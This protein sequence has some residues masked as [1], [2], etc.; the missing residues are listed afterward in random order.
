MIPVSA[1]S[2]SLWGTFFFASFRLSMYSNSTIIRS[3][4]MLSLAVL[5][6]CPYLLWRSACH[7]LRLYFDHKHLWMTHIYSDMRYLPACPC[8]R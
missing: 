6:V 7:G 1:C 8:L 3:G 2:V 4:T 5:V